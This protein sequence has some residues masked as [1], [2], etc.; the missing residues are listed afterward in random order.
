M[1]KLNLDHIAQPLRRLAVDLSTVVPDPRNARTHSPDQVQAI[2][3][4]MK[5]FG[6]DQPLVV[7]LQG[8]VVR[9]GNGRLEAATLNGWTHLPAVIVDESEVDAQCRALADNRLSD[10][11]G[12]DDGVLRELLAEAPDDGVPGWTADQIAELVQEAGEQADP[13]LGRLS[14]LFV[15]PPFNVLD[16]KQGYW[17]ERKREWM[18]LGVESELGR[19]KGENGK[20]RVFTASVVGLGNSPKKTVSIFDPVLCEIAYRW[21]C[22]PGGSILDPFA[23]GSVRGIVASRLGRQYVGIELRPEQIESN[24]EQ[25]DRICAEPFPVWIEGDAVNVADLTAQD[26]PYDFVFSCPPYGDLERYSDD[27][28]DLSAMDA[29]TFDA[30]YAACLSDACDRL[31]PDRFAV[32]VIGDVRDKRGRLRGLPA[33]TVRACEGSGLVFWNDAV[34]LTSIGSLPMRAEAGFNSS[35]K[36]V[37]GYQCVYVFA[38][39][40]PKS[41]TEAVGHVDVAGEEP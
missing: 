35:R 24:R 33:A 19:F 15:A 25:A 23:G 39:G 34:L 32:F 38:K 12:W 27:P 5:R 31:K 16:T 6:V 8:R 13:K 28:R 21:F 10:L 1:P 7:Q 9:K 11:A 18:A 20:G 40:N 22:P 30:T 2:A 36:L 4:S 26:E 29:E 37:R 17:Q 3:D 14:G 41:A